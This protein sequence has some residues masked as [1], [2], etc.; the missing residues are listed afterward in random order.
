MHHLALLDERW[1]GTVIIV[2]PQCFGLEYGLE[3]YLNV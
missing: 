1:G 3:S 2:E